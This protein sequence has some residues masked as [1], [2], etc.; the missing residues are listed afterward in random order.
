MP[1]LALPGLRD[2]WIWLPFWS[3][4]MV[5]PQSIVV[6]SPAKRPNRSPSSS[7]S[8]RQMYCTMICSGS[9]RPSRAQLVGADDLGDDEVRIE[10]DQKL[11]AVVVEEAVGAA[12][13]S[14]D[15]VDGMKDVQ[16]QA[17]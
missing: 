4:T 10:G 3:S 8:S 14:G 2:Q 5:A 12:A 1:T 16:R 15:G 13:R 6:R 11:G 17:A 9:E 7:N